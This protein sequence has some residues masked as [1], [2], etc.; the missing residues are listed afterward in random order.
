[1][2]HILLSLPLIYLR[3]GA[4]CPIP[5]PSLIISLDIYVCVPLVLQTGVLLYTESDNTVI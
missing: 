3:H 4:L 2:S 5:H 1:M